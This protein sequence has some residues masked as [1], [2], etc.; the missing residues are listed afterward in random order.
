M[1]RAAQPTEVSGVRVVM[2]KE[3]RVDGGAG[4]GPTGVSR[5]LTGLVVGSGEMRQEPRKSA[6]VVRTLSVNGSPDA[7]LFTYTYCYVLLW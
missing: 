7:C 1:T 5:V 3:Q 6:W 4:R 2:A